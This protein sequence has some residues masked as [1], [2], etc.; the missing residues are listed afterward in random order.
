MGHIYSSYCL[1]LIY[2]SPFVRHPLTIVSE[3]A[4][5]ENASAYFPLLD[6]IASG[7]FSQLS[8][9]AE[10]YKNFVDVVQEDGIIN[11]PEALSTFNLGLSLRASAPRVEA[12]YQYY[13]TAVASKADVSCDTW[14]LLDGNQYCTPQLDTATKTGLF[15]L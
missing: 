5:A 10:L 1:S 8:S 7:R 9:E 14:V 2:L 11:S 13:E 4:T 12:H 6:R 3:T 15:P